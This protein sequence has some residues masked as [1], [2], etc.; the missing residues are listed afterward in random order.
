MP[1]LDVEMVGEVP[2]GLAA[3]LAEAAGRA[4]DSRAGG[5]WVKVRALSPAHYAENGEMDAGV[6]PVFV[7]L[8]ERAPPE[9]DALAARVMALAEAIAG[10]CDRPRENVHVIVEPKGAGRVAFGGVLVR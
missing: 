8:I 7:R 1:I 5:T 9:G 10:A 3:T 2:D 4:L 6:Q